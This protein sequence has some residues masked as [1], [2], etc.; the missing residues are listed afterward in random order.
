M[1]NSSLSC[2]VSKLKQAAQKRGFSSG[3]MYVHAGNKDSPQLGVLIILKGTADIPHGYNRC[4]GTL[5]PEFR[6]HKKMS[7]KNTNIYPKYLG[8]VHL[9]FGGGGG[10]NSILGVCEILWPPPVSACFCS[11]PLLY[12]FK[13]QDPFILLCGFYKKFPL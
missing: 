8:T 2:V 4:S 13:N 12:S 9:K 10:Y 5:R 3:V 7:G 6:M 11:A 1:R